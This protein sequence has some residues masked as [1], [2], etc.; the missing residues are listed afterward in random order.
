[1]STRLRGHHAPC[2]IRAAGAT[3]LPLITNGESST[4]SKRSPE[5]DDALET[6]L[7]RRTVTG[8]PAG[9][10]MDSTAAGFAASAFRSAKGTLDAEFEAVAESAFVVVVAAFSAVCV[11]PG[12]VLQ[13]IERAA[14]RV[15]GSRSA[16]IVFFI[17]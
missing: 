14:V 8:V 6:A 3:V 12:M 10:V 16:K 5:F 4:A 15:T 11:V 9:T 2:N 17:T 1:M 7:C 13:P